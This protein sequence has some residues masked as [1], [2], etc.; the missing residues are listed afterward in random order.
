MINLSGREIA[1]RAAHSEGN[2]LAHGWK[3]FLTVFRDRLRKGIE[4]TR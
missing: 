4:L 2:G 3:V 1:V